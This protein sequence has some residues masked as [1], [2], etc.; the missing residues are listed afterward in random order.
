[1][2]AHKHRGLPGNG[3]PARKTPGE[4]HRAGKRFGYKI[5]RRTREFHDISTAQGADI[6][7]RG[8]GSRCA[9]GFLSVAQVVNPGDQR[10][11][12]HFRFSAG[13]K[14]SLLFLQR[15]VRLRVHR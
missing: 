3:A 1:M 11:P 15:K 10:E 14:G 2:F 13:T 12:G 5:V 4:A 6:A 8:S 7:G 9:A